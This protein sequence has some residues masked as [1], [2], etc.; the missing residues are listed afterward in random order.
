MP[1][2]GQTRSPQTREGHF[3]A[4]HPQ[5]NGCAPRKISI[6]TKAN[7]KDASGRAVPSR[8]NKAD[9]LQSRHDVAKHHE[10]QLLQ[11]QNQTHGT[12]NLSRLW[13]L[14]PPRTVM[15]NNLLSNADREAA[16]GLQFGLSQGFRCWLLVWCCQDATS[17]SMHPAPSP[18]A[19]RMRTDAPGS[20]IG[21]LVKKKYK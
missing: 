18:A 4:L 12:R 21:A 19:L 16:P 14:P 20:R 1:S 10:S 11:Q 3:G 17:S 2:A 5:H 13:F 15:N 7:T 6:S 8:S 9:T